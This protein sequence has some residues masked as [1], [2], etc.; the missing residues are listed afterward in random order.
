MPR[1]VLLADLRRLLGQRDYLLGSASETAREF[2]RHLDEGV[3]GKA[4]DGEDMENDADPSDSARPLPCVNCGRLTF[5]DE[6][7]RAYHWDPSEACA[8]G[9]ARPAM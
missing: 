1:A 2:I 6:E 9:A 8:E 7:G 4:P 5:L 3:Y